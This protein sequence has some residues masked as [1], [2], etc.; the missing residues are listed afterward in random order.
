MLAGALFPGFSVLSIKT[1]GSF[2]SAAPQ[3][4]T[5]TLRRIAVNSQAVE[6]L[7]KD[8]K[9]VVDLTQR[10]VVY[11]FHPGSGQIDFSRVVVR[12]A[13]GE[14]AIGPFLK[15]II[16]KD[17]LATFKYASQS[18][19]LG[20]RPTGTLATPPTGTSKILACGKVSCVCSGHDCFDMVFGGTFG[21]KEYCTGTIFCSEDENGTTWCSCDKAQ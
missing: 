20:T 13:R 12:T 3:A 18:F 6:V 5:T 2:S 17:K 1:P 8:K 14:I 16:P 15:R 4:P 10:G 11:R 19:S 7:P 21:G 9:Y